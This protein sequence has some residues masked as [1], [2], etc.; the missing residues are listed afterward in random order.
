MDIFDD[1]TNDIASAVL[2][3]TPTRAPRSLRKAKVGTP[4]TAR[5]PSAPLP[6]PSAVHAPMPRKATRSQRKATAAPQ[7]KA[8]APSAHIEPTPADEIVQ[9]WRMR[10]R[11]HR[12][13]K[14]LRL[15]GKAFCR[16]HTDGDKEAGS[17]LFDEARAG[18][19][20]AHVVFGLMPFFNAIDS[21]GPERKQIE[22]RL[23]L[24]AQ[25]LP[26]WPWV[27]SV[28]G[29]GDLNLAALVGE[30]GDIGSYRSPAA[31]W[32]RMGLAVIGGGRQRRVTDA[33]LA[34]EHGYSP[35]RRSVAYLLGG[36]LIKTG[37]EESP[38]RA[39]YAARKEYE[40]ARQDEGKP[41]SQ[42]HAHNRAARYMTKRALRDLWSAWRKA[43]AT[44]DA[45][46]TP[47]ARSLRKAMETPQPT[48]F[49]PSAPIQ[50]ASAIP[51]QSTIG[52]V[53]SQRKASSA[54]QPTQ[55]TPSALIPETSAADPPSPMSRAR[56]SR[57]AKGATQ[58]S[59]TSPSALTPD[60]SAIIAASPVGRPRSPRKA[61][62]AA[63]APR[64]RSRRARARG[65]PVGR[66]A[67][68]ASARSRGR[69]RRG[70]R[71]GRR[72]LSAARR[73]RDGRLEILRRLLRRARRAEAEAAAVSAHA[74]RTCR[75]ASVSARSGTLSDPTRCAARWLGQWASSACRRSWP[76]LHRLAIHAGAR[77]CRGARS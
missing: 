68:T 59:L 9:G 48:G 69:R 39:I 66:T 8:E 51:P 33:E 21:F 6:D 27:A 71:R 24:L 31:I 61:T 38:Y 13:E 64:R 34:L 11:W 72:R 17:Q 73:E 1:I 43:S 19:A 58:P 49:A 4:P 47:G 20:P 55:L 53:R 37:G 62:L 45:T 77:P 57:K 46:P 25:S 5:S 41:K 75:G 32:K 12:A 44:V 35:N 16:A 40:L 7:P 30:C 2:H 67:S 23:R 3:A 18:N 76:R 42:G 50:N 15:Q 28:K 10:Q 52:H 65:R 56:S 29:F 36:T 26:V 60:A 63:Q 70:G 14:S 54:S 22:K 74:A